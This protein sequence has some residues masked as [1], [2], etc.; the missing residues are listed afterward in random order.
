[1]RQP[2]K[3]SLTIAFLV[4]FLLGVGLVEFFSIDFKILL[5]IFSVALVLI[6]FRK[7]FP[8]ILFA[9]TIL[10]G[11]VFGFAR[12]QFAMQADPHALAKFNDLDKKVTIT[13]IISEEP[14]RRSDHA[15]YTIEAEKWSDGI[16]EKNVNGRILLRTDLLPEY[17]YGDEL[18]IFGKLEA[19][20]E[21]EEFSYRDYLDRYGIHSV[22]YRPSIEKIS[23]HNRNR[24]FEW[25]FAFKKSFEQKINQI[26]PE[27]AASLEAGLLIGSRRGIPDSVL[28]DFNT[29]GLT[30][31][32]A[33]SGYNISLVIAFITA[34]FGSFVPRRFQFPLAII[35][36]TA[37]TLLVGAG[38]AVVRASIM[39]LLAFF[40]LTHG[41]QYHVGLAFV[42]TAAVMVFW[43]PKILLHD[44][45]F[46]LSFAAVAGLLFVGPLLEK[47]FAKIP[48]KF[49]IRESLLLT[50]SAQVTAVP[51]IVFYFA[52]LS[53]VAPLANLLVAPAI[54]LAMLL[55]FIAVGVGA[56]FLPA[57]LLIGFAAY[58]LLE[59]IL[60]VTEKLA[61]IPFA[62]FAVTNFSIAMVVIYYLALAGFLI[63]KNHLSKKTE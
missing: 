15:K 57:G 13:G 16:V 27:P 40:A 45:S 6:F 31:I 30:H 59:Y 1:M 54:P 37:F 32:I 33:I 3:S 10:L 17:F 5:T 19:P 4:A 55:G 18:K 9:T 56:I 41:R 47:Y 51:L 34:L 49:A 28:Q 25:L 39:G 24:I 8:S 7:K 53:I 63:W 46:Q 22:M 26:F 60:F 21:T 11:L 62:S 48:N 35:F 20:F 42:L 38:P 52:R 23:A 2:K 61:A 29:T 50:L 44:V 36:V 14:D 12:F 43:N 58:G